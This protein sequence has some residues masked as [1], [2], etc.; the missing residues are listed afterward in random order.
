LLEVGR[1][2]ARV[3]MTY[4]L[5]VYCNRIS[6]ASRGAVLYDKPGEFSGYAACLLALDDLA[7]DEVC[8][9]E[10][11]RPTQPGLDRRSRLVHIVTPQAGRCL[12]PQSIPGSQP[13]GQQAE[14]MAGYQD[15]VPQVPGVPGSA[16]DFEA[17]FTGV[18]GS[19]HAAVAA[20]HQHP[21]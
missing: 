18:A 14:G 4:L 19:R 3:H 1:R 16:E 11:D 10:L 5:P 13:A 15:A 21:L 12:E 9:A 2:A 8:F 20:V 6:I 17:V 7:A